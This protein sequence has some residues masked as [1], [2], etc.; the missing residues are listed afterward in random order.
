M[1][2]AYPFLDKNS[3]RKGP[4]YYELGTHGCDRGGKCRRGLCCRLVRREAIEVPERQRRDWKQLGY[5]P[6]VVGRGL[7]NVKMREKQVR[8]H[9]HTRKGNMAKE[10]SKPR[11]V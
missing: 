1:G 6:V 8:E 7:A 10:Q 5:F 9:M 11:E 3:A 4:S 2:A